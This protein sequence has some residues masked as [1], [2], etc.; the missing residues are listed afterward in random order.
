MDLSQD[1]LLLEMTQ[2]SLLK[3]YWHFGGIYCSHLDGQITQPVCFTQS[4]FPHWLLR[5]V[6]KNVRQEDGSFCVC[7]YVRNVW[8]NGGVMCW[9]IVFVCRKRQRR[10]SWSHYWTYANSGIRRG[11]VFWKVRQVVAPRQIR[12]SVPSCSFLM[13]CIVR[14]VLLLVHNISYI[15]CIKTSACSYIFPEN[16]WQNL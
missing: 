8:L 7:H 2:C 5:D 13:R 16:S 1:R 15:S 11:N 12:G 6:Y 9:L 14:Y 3:V 10:H 4:P